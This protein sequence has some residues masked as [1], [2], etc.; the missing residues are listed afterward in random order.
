LANFKLYMKV[1]NE[2]DLIFLITD[3]VHDNFDVQ[4]IGE[5]PIDWNISASSWDEAAKLFPEKTGQVKGAFMVNQMKHV[6][7]A[8]STAEL[9][10]DMVTYR[11]VE[12]SSALT[13]TT[14]DWV[15]ANPRKKLPHDAVRFPGKMDHCSCVC[16]K[17]TSYCK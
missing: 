10:P 4:N 12:A 6:L 17:V 13:Q 7:L 3:G 1:C 9:T 16:F 11:L 8:D 2:G 14:R 15:E 5:T